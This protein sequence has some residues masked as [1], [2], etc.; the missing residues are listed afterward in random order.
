MTTTE[1]LNDVDRLTDRFRDDGSPINAWA[2]PEV[3]VA[4]PRCAQRAV[5]RRVSAGAPARRLSCPGCGLSKETA[6]N[7]SSWGGPFDPWFALPLWLQA[8]FRGHTAWAYNPRHLGEL[9]DCVAATHRERKPAA[10]PSM[11]MVEKLPSWMTSAKNRD[12]LVA[13]LD[14][15]STGA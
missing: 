1:I 11:S 6:G 9:R 12:D 2:E 14:R 3:L 15:M 10:N 7:T 13:I 4:C 5:V 8:G